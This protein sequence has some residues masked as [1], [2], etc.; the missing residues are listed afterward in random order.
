MKRRIETIYL[1]L[2]TAELAGTRSE[3]KLIISGVRSNSR[4]KPGEELWINIH[5]DIKEDIPEYIAKLLHDE[6]DNRL[7]NAVKDVNSFGKNVKST[8]SKEEKSTTFSSLLNVV[9]GKISCTTCGEKPKFER[10]MGGAAFGPGSGDGSV[11]WVLT[12]ECSHKQNIE[13][14][15]P[16]NMAVNEWETKNYKL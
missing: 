4:K 2:L 1:E 3:P 11:Y 6:M 12:C 15:R 7:K 14:I 16:L 13:P 10:T 9:D 8:L 5:I